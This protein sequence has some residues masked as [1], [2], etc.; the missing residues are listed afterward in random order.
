MNFSLIF[1]ISSSVYTLVFVSFERYRAIIDS[2]ESRMTYKK[3]TIVIVIIWALALAISIPTL[4]E[5]SV[6]KFYKVIEN[7]T[8]LF[9]SCGS[10]TTQKLGL[11]NA[12]FVFIISYVIPVILMLKNYT[13]VALFVWE[14]G[15]RIEDSSTA[16]GTNVSSFHLLQ[17]RLKLVKLL[18]I[19]AMTFAMSWLPFYIML[20]YAVSRRL[21]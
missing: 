17:H 10:E 14:K 20:I 5:Y 6:Q 15:K 7:E 8:V 11:S 9:V 19:V 21:M 1:V 18:V 3:L 4:L 2:Q 12:V 16:R 13:Q